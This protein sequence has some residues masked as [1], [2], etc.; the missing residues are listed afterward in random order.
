MRERSGLER[1]LEALG[2]RDR[3]PSE[4]EFEGV[5]ERLLRKGQETL[6][7]T[8]TAV[9]SLVA[10]KRT[11]MTTRGK[12]DVEAHLFPSTSDRRA[13]I[14][15]G[16][17]GSELSAI[18]VAERLVAELRT[19]PTPHFKVIVI[20]CLFPDNAAVARANPA[21][22][23]STSNIGRKTSGNPVDPN[24]QFPPLGAPFDPV[25]KKDA[26]GRVIEPENVALLNLIASFKPERIANLH[27]HRTESH[28]GI[29]ADPRT[30]AVGLALGYADDEKLALAMARHAAARGAKVPGNALD[31]ATPNAVYPLD[32]AAVTAG[33]CQPREIKDGISLGGWGST[34]VAD[35]A[36]PSR[37]RPAMRVITVEV[38]TSKR[39]QDLTD[40]NRARQKAFRDARS[41]EYDAHV[42]ALRDIFLGSP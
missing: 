11:L 9:Q 34:A 12:R 23:G 40:A 3:S 37:N 27:A 21:Q 18:E 31:Q 14:V 33:R 13:L 19:N 7:S 10:G 5:L 16:V 15:A 38:Q 22:I 6:G 4:Q 25:G 39:I 20:P 2:I 36:N 26:K 17:H 8:A 30:D 41:K 29:Y 28:A 42:R 35:P 32:P 24:R 1:E